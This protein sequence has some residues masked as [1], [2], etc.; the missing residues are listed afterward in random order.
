M[1]EITKTPWGSYKVIDSQPNYQIKEIVVKPEQAPSYQYHFKRKE[2][3]VIINGKG[4]LKLN[5]ELYIIETGDTI[6]IGFKDK[7]QVKNIGK[8]DL[9][10]VEIQTGTYFGEDDIVRLNDL[11]GRE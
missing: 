1:N 9:V 10:F 6:D 4:E 5:D 2:T 11:Y 3:W 7:H 8:E